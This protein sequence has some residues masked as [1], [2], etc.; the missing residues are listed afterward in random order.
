MNYDLL[1]SNSSKKK[2][3]LA[4]IGVGGF[5]HSLFTYG[6]R[7]EK[8]SIRSLCGR[9]IQKCV[10]AYLAAGVKQED[11]ADCNDKEK[12]LKAYAAG[13]SLVFDDVKLA[14]QMP[15]D[16]VVEG[17]GNPEASATYALH[18]I[19]NGKSVV[20]V[21]KESD[22]VVGPLLSKKA[23][24][25]GVIYSL[26]EGDQPSLL[27]GL[28]TWVKN[29]GLTILGIGKASEYDF[30]YDVAES[31][32][33]VL[34]KKVHVP[35]FADVWDLGDDYAATVKKRSEMLKMFNQRAIPDLAEMSIVCNHLSDF[36]PDV[37]AVPLSDRPFARGGRPDVPEGDGRIVQRQ[38]A[39]RCVQLPASNR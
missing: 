31:T 21:T 23:R 6:M 20:N 19:E 35:G 1:F 2:V 11:I 26:A 28:V 32:V 34:G 22:V 37:E 12:G 15:F 33:E 38:Q 5:N 30:I 39:D 8:L 14:M 16:V 13:K 4:I 17:T 27:V 36:D 10:E 3:E 18:A 29:A 25:K 7:N 9:N 24:E